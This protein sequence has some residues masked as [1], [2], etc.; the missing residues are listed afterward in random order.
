MEGG[1]SEDGESDES[2]VEEVDGVEGED[3]TNGGEERSGCGLSFVDDVGEGVAGREEAGI[4]PLN[5]SLSL[6]PLLETGVCDGFF[7]IF[8]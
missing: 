6:G 2:G 5:L 3:G 7:D 4:T 8:T 1:A